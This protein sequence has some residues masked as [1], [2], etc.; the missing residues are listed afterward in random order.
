MANGPYKENKHGA[1]KFKLPKFSSSKDII[2]SMCNGDLRELGCGMI[3]G[4]DSMES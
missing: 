2:W 1:I 4:R 3:I